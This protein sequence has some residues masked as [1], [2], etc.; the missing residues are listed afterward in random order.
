M[1]STGG[2]HLNR[3]AERLVSFCRK[4]MNGDLRSVFLYAPDG[5]EL[6]YGREDVSEE[7]D[8]EAFV[9]FSKAATGVTEAVSGLEDTAVESSLGEYRVTV[10]QFE[11]VFAFQFHRNGAEGIVA[12]FDGGIGTQLRAF[13]QECLDA[14]H[15]G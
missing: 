9:R 13:S 3:E 11:N 4:R 15:D 7:H 2:L 8:R 12:S 14:I 6:V 10:H 5:G 1:A